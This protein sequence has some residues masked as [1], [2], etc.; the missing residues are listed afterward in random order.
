MLTWTPGLMFYSQATA[1]YQA[2]EKLK[3]IKQ[4]KKG[5]ISSEELIKYAHRIS[6]TNAVAAP[7]TWAPGIVFFQ[8]SFKVFKCKNLPVPVKCGSLTSL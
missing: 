1:I 5:A 2:K 6:A 7:L 3:A 8:Y 4:A